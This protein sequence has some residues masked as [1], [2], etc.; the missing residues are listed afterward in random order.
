[1][2]VQLRL[3]LRRSL[4][5]VLACRLSDRS[6]DLLHWSSPLLCPEDSGVQPR[7]LEPRRL[8]L[9]GVLVVL[10]VLELDALRLGV[11]SAEQAPGLSSLDHTAQSLAYGIGVFSGVGRYHCRCCWTLIQN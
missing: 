3:V 11:D 2:L 7:G 8:P 4:V 6:I 10:T 1:V 5:L 9:A